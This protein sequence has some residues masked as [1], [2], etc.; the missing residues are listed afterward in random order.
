[1][2]RLR[3]VVAYDGTDFHGFQRQPGVETVQGL[4]ERRLT[5][6]CG[7]P[8]EV[9]G[10]GRTDTGVHALGQVVHF[11][12]E[13]EIAPERLGSALNRELGPAVRVRAVEQAP[14]TFHARFTAVERS[15]EYLVALSVSSPFQTRYV[16]EWP[17][18]RPDAT[19]RMEEAL[20]AAVGKFDFLP[21]SVSEVRETV[22][23]VRE[24]RVSESAGLLRIRIAADAFLR[25]MV[26]LLVGL[27]LEIGE[28]RR[29]TGVIR[30]V[31][32]AGTREAAGKVFRAAPPQG[33]YLAQVR[34]PDGYGEESLPN[35]AGD[36]GF[37]ANGFTGHWSLDAPGR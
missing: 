8:V 25:S 4:L 27:A 21:F 32:E 20:G 19:E 12:T 33:L 17:G 7:S 1:M 28:G 14:E 26:R 31:L 3:L 10:A 6:I 11:E 29:E 30:Q 36:A 22:R 35:V 13:C 16:V 24:V 15:Y 18:L 23:T 34:Y 9:V 2:R 5:R 37:G